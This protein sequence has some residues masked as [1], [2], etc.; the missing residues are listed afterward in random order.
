[1]QFRFESNALRAGKRNTVGSPF[2]LPFPNV[3]LP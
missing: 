1:M 3:E 2:H